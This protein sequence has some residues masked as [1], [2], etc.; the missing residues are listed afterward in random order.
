MSQICPTILADSRVSYDAQLLR[1]QSFAERVQI[2]V[3][4]G[5]FAPS[6]TIALTD[7][8]LPG[9]IL[10]DIHVMYKKPQDYAAV[11]QKLRPNMVIVHAESNCDIPRFAA[12]MREYGIKTGV[13]LLPETSVEEIAYLLPHVQHVLIFSGHLGFFGGDA[14]LE[15]AKKA[16]TIK[17][18]TPHIEIGWDGGA[19]QTNCRQLAEAG[20]DVINVGGAIQK[21]DNPETTYA[22]MK[23]IVT[24]V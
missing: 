24:S 21:S 5:D 6:K 20:I 16:A 1:I 3:T 8:K 18:I 12:A 10:S 23:A 9:G 22:T 13:A 11:L 14:N 19:N 2:D 4:D 7:I 15:L 17:N